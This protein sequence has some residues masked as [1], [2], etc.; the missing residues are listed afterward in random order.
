MASI[1]IRLST[2]RSTFC[3]KALGI[4]LPAA[5]LMSAS[6]RDLRVHINGRESRLHVPV[7]DP[8]E[9]QDSVSS[10]RVA[11]VP[12]NAREESSL[13]SCRN[14]SWANPFLKT[15]RAWEVYKLR[16]FAGRKQLGRQP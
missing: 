3:F 1:L 14:C 7:H 4:G 5:L 9:G 8:H 2:Q 11:D 12:R 10:P 15:R 6:L 16:G 13:A